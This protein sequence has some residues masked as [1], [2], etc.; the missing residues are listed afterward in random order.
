MSLPLAAEAPPLLT[1]TDGAVR[2]GGSRVTLDTVVSA[3]DRGHTAEEI[4]QQYPT[5]SLA[6]V[7]VGGSGRY[8][9]CPFD[10][11]PLTPTR[12]V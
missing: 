1:D 6:D 12:G 9:T 10:T 8:G 5:L 2:V 3:F 4:Q 7:Y 11:T